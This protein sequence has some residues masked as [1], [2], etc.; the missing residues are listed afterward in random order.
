[1]EHSIASRYC[2]RKEKGGRMMRNI[3]DIKNHYLNH[4][5]EKYQ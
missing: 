4:K 5:L 1:M 3:M 2:S